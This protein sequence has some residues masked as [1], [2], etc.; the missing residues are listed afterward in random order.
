MTDGHPPLDVGQLQSFPC[1]GE[2]IA[3][4][5]TL[6]NVMFCAKDAGGVYIDVNTA[7]VRRTGRSSKRE[8]IG[9]HAT[10]LFAPERSE[11]YEAQD[12]RV[13][14]G[15]GPLRDQ[16]ELIR[17]PDGDL[18]WYLTTKLPVLD[19]AV[20]S[21]PIGLVSVSRDL[22]TPTDEGVPVKSLLPMV[23]FVRERLQEP[24]RVADL[25]AAAGCSPS[26][27]DR[28][29]KR[30]FGL[31][32]KQ[33]VL[34]VKVERAMTLLNETDAGLGEIANL[35]GFYDQPDFSRRFAKITGRTPAQFRSS[36]SDLLG[37]NRPGM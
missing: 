3:L 20:G 24:L 19:P 8:V 2:L 10:D 11:E 4:F 1:Q 12:R 33:Y 26:Q 5:E 14:S 36:S 25:A 21:A 32:P 13:L 35:A 18:G 7:F 27:L 30:V 37:V 17:R 28:R 23:T 6:V 34:R 15:E 16:L 31:S 22:Q 29:V 9:R